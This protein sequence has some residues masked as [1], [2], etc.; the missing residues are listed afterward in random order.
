MIISQLSYKSNGDWIIDV[1][2]WDQK[3]DKQDQPILQMLRNGRICYTY[4]ETWCDKPI[5]N[6]VRSTLAMIKSSFLFFLFTP[7]I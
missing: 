5:R 3:L 2:H 6:I 4:N 7:G 1:N